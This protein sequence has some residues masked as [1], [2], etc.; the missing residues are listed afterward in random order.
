MGPKNNFPD[1]QDE[2][3]WSDRVTDYDRKHFE[4]YVRLLDATSTGANVA[5][6]SSK[7]LGIDAQVESE[8]AARVIENHLKRAK[9]M[10]THGYRQLLDPT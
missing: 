9:W 5:E 3:P 10:T 2:V 6:I 7:L 4:L 8:R 1:F